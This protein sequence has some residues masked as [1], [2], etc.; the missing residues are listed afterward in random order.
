MSS[1][2]H[3]IIV[4]GAT[5]QSDRWLRALDAEYAKVDGRS[6]E[7]LLRFAPDFGRLIHFFNLD[8]SHD[9]PKH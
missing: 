5:S 8:M 4:N 9:R 6:P 2:C 7:D 3:K 1:T